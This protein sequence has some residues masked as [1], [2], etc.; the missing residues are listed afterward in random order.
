MAVGAQVVR[1]LADEDYGSRG[2]TVTRKGNTWGFGTYAGRIVIGSARDGHVQGCQA[3]GSQL[4]GATEST[5]Y[6]TPSFKVRNKG[7]C[8]MW[9][10]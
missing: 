1:E 6:G 7:F 4:P 10:R 2:Y 8:R 3:P 9:S 5:S